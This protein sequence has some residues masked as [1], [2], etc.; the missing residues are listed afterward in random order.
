MLMSGT[1]A[2]G[3]IESTMP[4]IKLD[5]MPMWSLGD[6]P[7]SYPTGS[8]SAMYISAAS[9]VKDQAAELLDFLYAPDSAKLMIEKASIIAPVAMDA[10][11]LTLSAFQKRSV[12]AVTTGDGDPKVNQGVFVN[13]GLSGSA[14]HQMMT[15]GFQAMM[16]GQKTADKQAA[17]LQAA[18]EKDN[19]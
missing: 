12:S 5:I 2:A 15:N 9:K 17:D 11:T 3:N 13:H 16:A 14:F 7:R 6:K 4:N 10:S 18:W 1:W 19:S 8:G